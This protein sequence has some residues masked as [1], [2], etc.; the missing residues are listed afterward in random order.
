MNEANTQG[1]EAED[2]EAERSSDST[3]SSF[4]KDFLP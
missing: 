3:A 1:I 2:G 4:A